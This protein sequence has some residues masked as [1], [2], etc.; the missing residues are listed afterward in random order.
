[1]NRHAGLLVVSLLAVACAGPVGPA[2]APSRSGSA[3]PSVAPYALYVADV[4]GPPI[5]L[6]IG[7]RLV[8]QVSCSGYMTLTAGANGVPQLPWPLDVRRQGG[9][10]LQHFEVQ[11][12]Q[13]FT[14]LL[15]GDTVALGQFGAAG[16]TS[17]PDACA[18]W[19][20]SLP[21]LPAPGVTPFPSQPA[22]EV[23]ADD[24]DG[25]PIEV[26]IGGMVVVSVPCGG[27]ML[28]PGVGSVPQL[29]WA[30]DVRRQGGPLLKHFDVIGG[31]FLML[32]LRGDTIA[33]G[34]FA[35]DGRA[36]S[37]ARARRGAPDS[38]RDSYA[39]ALRPPRLAPRRLHRRSYHRRGSVLGG[40]PV[41]RLASPAGDRG[42]HPAL[43]DRVDRARVAAGD[44]PTCAGDPH[45]GGRRLVSR[46]RTGLGPATRA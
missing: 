29:P 19:A 17:A 3:A 44:E 10:L 9:G 45:A 12:G 21:A 27:A 34:T 26:L 14:L 38:H 11:G 22:F 6:L 5:D 46:A 8:A 40:R 16:P 42:A 41:G 25:P 4:D 33:P 7:D 35:G 39:V 30:L 43:R 15:R 31:Q 32:L 1:M 23:Y 36:P 24:V 18:R 37:R 2:A 28:V 20:A 13:D